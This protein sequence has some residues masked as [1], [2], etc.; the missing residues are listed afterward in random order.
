MIKIIKESHK[1]DYKTIYTGTCTGCGSVIE[2]EQ[3]DIQNIEWLG[4]GISCPVCNSRNI[5]AS[6]CKTRQEKIVE[7]EKQYRETL[8]SIDTVLSAFCLAFCHGKPPRSTCQS[9]GTCA[10][11]DIFKKHLEGGEE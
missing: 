4:A 5:K 6:E 11:Y 7:G 3:E 10:E 8:Y 1:N 9:L 2:F